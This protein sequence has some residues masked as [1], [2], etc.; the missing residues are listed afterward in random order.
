MLVIDHY[1]KDWI[2]T[3][4][5]TM[6]ESPLELTEHMPT[7]DLILNH[8]NEYDDNNRLLSL[9]IKNTIG[10]K[11][12]DTFVKGPSWPCGSWIYNY[13]CNQCLLPL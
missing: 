9:Y 1:S 8:E 5:R 2:Y 11:E 13:Q 7:Y 12:A 3:I 10:Q 6:W 4:K